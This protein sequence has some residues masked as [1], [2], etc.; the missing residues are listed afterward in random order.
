MSHTV[1][2]AYGDSNITYRG[3]TI[4]DDSRH[5]MMVLC[6]E[7]VSANQIWSIVSSVVLSALRSQGFGIHFVNSFTTEIAQ[8]VGFSYVDDCDVVQ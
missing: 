3:D 2:T 1:S 6:Q 8:L 4:P 7:N 5:F